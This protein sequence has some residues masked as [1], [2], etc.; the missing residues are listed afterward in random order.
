MVVVVCCMMNV[1]HDDVGARYGT[2]CASWKIY[3]AA[4]G[5][6]HVFTWM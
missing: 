2:G 3:V 5:N 4:V 6:M 1:G